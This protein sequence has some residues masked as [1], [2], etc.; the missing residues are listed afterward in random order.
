MET[1]LFPKCCSIGHVYHLD[2]NEGTFECFNYSASSYPPSLLN[3]NPQKLFLTAYQN[4]LPYDEE[5]YEIVTGFPSNCNSSTIRYVEPDENIA[6]RFYLT[7]SGKLIFP[8][9]FNF[10]NYKDYCI[11]EFVMNKDFSQVSLSRARLTFK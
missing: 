4:P 6:K 10:L 9:L 1:L 11:E 7:R 5:D 8:H 3:E 2:L